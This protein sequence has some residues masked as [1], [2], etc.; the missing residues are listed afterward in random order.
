M[1]SNIQ[2]NPTIY[3]FFLLVQLGL[4]V[5]LLVEFTIGS[6]TQ[7]NNVYIDIILLVQLV[8]ASVR[9]CDTLKLRL[10]EY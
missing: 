9:G 4:E 5:I 8:A 3:T 10:N 2:H 1:G 7:H 6:K